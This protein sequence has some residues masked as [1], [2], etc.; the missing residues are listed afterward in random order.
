MNLEQ[1][2]Q[3]IRDLGVGLGGSSE[4]YNMDAQ[5]RLNLGGLKK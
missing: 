3:L 1:A 2:Q 4:S 5:G